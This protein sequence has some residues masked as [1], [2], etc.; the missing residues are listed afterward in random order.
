MQVFEHFI[1]FP[2]EPAFWNQEPKDNPKLSF[3]YL[4]AYIY[5]LA[6][7]SGN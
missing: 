2:Q 3:L 4:S 7:K 6:P 5:V 1:Q